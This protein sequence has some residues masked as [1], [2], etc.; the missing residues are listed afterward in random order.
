MG[1]KKTHASVANATS[2]KAGLAKLQEELRKSWSAQAT[3]SRVEVRNF[4]PQ[5]AQRFSQYIGRP[6]LLNTCLVMCS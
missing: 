1:F 6:V 2:Q 5:E 4:R 3:P